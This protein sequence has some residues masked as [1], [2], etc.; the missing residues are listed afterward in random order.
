MQMPRTC[1]CESSHARGEES[2][3]GRG[4]EKRREQ[5]RMEGRGREERRGQERKEGEEGVGKEEEEGG[6][7]EKIW[8]SIS[9]AHM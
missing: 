6:E 9:Y 3:E 2:R 4:G 1:I 8:V 7:T 5:R